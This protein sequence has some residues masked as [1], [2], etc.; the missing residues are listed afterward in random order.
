MWAKQLLLVELLLLEVKA[1]DPQ[2]TTYVFIMKANFEQIKLMDV[3]AENFVERQHQLIS[4]YI[5][6]F[7]TL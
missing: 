5:K 1:S 3:L 7:T 2:R 6:F 4:G